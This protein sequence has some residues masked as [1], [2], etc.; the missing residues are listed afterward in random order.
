MKKNLFLM[1]FCL[2]FSLYSV[3]QVNYQTVTVPV[4]NSFEGEFPSEGW[5]WN[6]V[7]NDWTHY[8][9][10]LRI[11]NGEGNLISP[12]IDL[13]G[14]ED[15]AV[16]SFSQRQFYNTSAQMEVLIS[17]DRQNWDL[18]YTIPNNGTNFVYSQT[19]IPLTGNYS[20]PVS[21]A[22]RYSNY[23][24][25]QYLD[26]EYIEI[27]E[28][29]L[30]FSDLDYAPLDKSATLS[31]RGF[32]ESDNNFNFVIKRNGE[33]ISSLTFDTAVGLFIDDGLEDGMEYCYE[34][35]QILATGTII[36]ETKCIETPSCS[37]AL[38][39]VLGENFAPGQNVWY[40]FTPQY[41]TEYTIS[42]CHPNN[43]TDPYIY[44]YDTYLQVFES[45]NGELVAENDDM[46]WET[47]GNNRASSI[48]T[49]SAVAG[50]TYKVFW[51]HVSTILDDFEF[52]FTISFD[53]DTEP[54]VLT[55]PPSEELTV[56]FAFNAEYDGPF[57]TAWDLVDP[58]PVITSVPEMP[59]TYTNTGSYEIIW[60]ATDG[61]GNTSSS[62]QNITITPTFKRA[63]AIQ[64]PLLETLQATSNLEGKTAKKIEDAIKEL[65]KVLGKSS[66]WKENEE[67]LDPKK[68]KKF[69]RGVEKSA[70][71]L[72]DVIK[73]EKQDEQV[74]SQASVVAIKLSYISRGIV[75]YAI[76]LAELELEGENSQAII[77]A[78]EHLAIGDSKFPTKDYD[79]AIKEY[80]AAWEKIAKLMDKINGKGR[81]EAFDNN[82]DNIDDSLGNLKT[83]IDEVDHNNVINL[84]QNYPNPFVIRTTLDYSISDDSNVSIRIYD[85]KGQVVRSLVNENQR[86][87][88]Y[89]MTWNGT[90][91][92]GNSMPMGIYFVK[93]I[94]GN[95]VKTIRMIIK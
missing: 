51:P 1:A 67:E 17:T 90:N 73:D 76:E 62:T 55:I 83:S 20:G 57:A 50:H 46:D 53:C 6:Y 9:G 63:V 86:S 42:S 85:I 8:P 30:E 79:E 33:D 34:I 78:N 84:E 74:V 82:D 29:E 12:P 27:K 35:T 10:W 54:P 68:G 2:L 18:L 77:D 22:F 81:G 88:T 32:I 69:F 21:L 26:L 48:V 11:N 25:K 75:E 60:T 64:V 61:C 19:I 5:T 31:W 71:N 16:L 43:T 39:A 91:D 87:G 45:C 65:E 36:T 72:K 41:N 52:I 47:C 3:G 40:E 14:L 58:N 28:N 66:I 4:I 89:S 56:G 92:S 38:E 24:N 49:F 44:S 80:A 59:I 7:N 95:Q 93:L 94:A 13:S 37:Q 15:G 23:E 70:K